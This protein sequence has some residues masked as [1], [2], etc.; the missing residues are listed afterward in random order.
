ML[1]RGNSNG[2]SNDRRAGVVVVLFFFASLL[3]VA[4]AS[5][6]PSPDAGVTVTRD[7]VYRTIDGERLALDVY[8]PAATTSKRPAILLVHGG[9]WREGDKSDF[10]ED[11]MKLA[12]L[13]YAA[14][15][16]N[17]RLAPAHPY[18]AA[19]DDVEAAVGWVRGPAQ[20]K[21]YKLDPKR[22][23]AVGASA[24]GHLVGML[25]TLGQGSRTNGSR[26]KAAVSWSGPMDFNL[27]PVA[28]LAANPYAA[29]VL[30]FLDCTTDQPSCANATAASPISHVDR[31][32]APMLLANSE[33]EF[34]GLDHATSMD[35]ALKAAG[36]PDQL[37][38]FPGKRHAQGYDDDV[39]PQTVAFLRRYV[40]KPPIAKAG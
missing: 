8:V 36:V 31:T 22:V 5:G 10:T 17:Y 39:F 2:V 38:V 34:V 3:L 1:G 20:V 26:I 25:A 28:M 23:G 21:A 29:A 6:L 24:G 27:W 19:V 12:Q 35:A 18:P 32:D 14:F 4:P 30:E 37:V 40:G 33:Q 16:I 13:G 15:S 11:G 9:S 7:V